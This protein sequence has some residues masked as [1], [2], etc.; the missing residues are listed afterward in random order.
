MPAWIVIVTGVVLWLIGQRRW[1]RQVSEN[2]SVP[3]GWQLSLLGL[4]G[5]GLGVYAGFR[6]PMT[7]GS[8]TLEAFPSS[9]LGQQSSGA[10]LDYVQA[11]VQIKSRPAP[12]WVGGSARSLECTVNNHGNRILS[13]LVLR[14]TSRGS[15]SGTVDLVLD[16]PFPEGRA[17]LAVLDVPP[18]VDHSYFKPPGITLSAVVGARF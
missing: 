5:I 13:R 2:R 10:A 16:G 12:G 7:I 6:G 4:V 15:E 1:R 18:N 17:T 11:H 14:L 8:V 9:Y 3:G